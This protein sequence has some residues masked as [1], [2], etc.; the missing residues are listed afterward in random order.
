M[1]GLGLHW[2]KSSRSASNGHCL[3]A[4]WRK[5]G[6]SINGGHCLEAAF[7]KS[8]FSHA[9]GSCTEAALRDGTVLVRDSRLGETSPVLAF[10]PGA[11]Q[12][13]LDGI[14]GT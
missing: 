1:S 7:R 14:K 5:S 10:S 13:F 2:R 3:E 9:N 6:R 11:W 8:S 12:V 4:R